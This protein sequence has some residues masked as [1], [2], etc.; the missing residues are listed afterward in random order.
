MMI[1][2]KFSIPDI[3]L[4]WFLFQYVLRSYLHKLNTTPL[5]GRKYALKSVEVYKDP[6]LLVPLTIEEGRF[7][8]PA[9]L[10]VSSTPV[11]AHIWFS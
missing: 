7:L 1:F 10:T 4:V 9:E 6:F 5:S 3:I 8:L 11:S 2:S